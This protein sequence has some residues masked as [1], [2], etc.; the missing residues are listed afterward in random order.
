MTLRS[1]HQFHI[2]VMGL[3]FTIDTALKVARFGISSVLSIVEDQ[4]IERMREIHSN[5]HGL[6]YQQIKD[7]DDDSRARRITAYLDLLDDLIQEQVTALRKEA[8]EKGTE[9]Y[10]YFE[11]LPETSLL[12]KEFNAMLEMSLQDKYIAQEALRSKIVAGSIDVNIMTKLDKTNYD[13]QKNPLPVEYNDAQAALR[14]FANSKCSSSIILSAGMNP[15]LFSYFEA[16]EDFIPNSLGELKKKVI[17]KVSDF[18]SAHIQ[19]KI[20]AKK[21]IWVSEF[22]I[23]SGLNCGGHAFA[24]DG[25]LMGPILEEFSSKR[26]DLLIELG[27]LYKAA[28]VEKK[29]LH[30]ES[31]PEQKLTVQ[32]GVGTHAEHEFLMNYF[33]VDATGWGSPFLLVPEVTNLDKG[34]LSQLASAKKEDYYLSESSPL[35]VP[36]NN[37]RN[38]SSD[39][40]R[41]QRLEKGKPGSPCYKKFLSLNTE[42]T[43]RPVCTASRQY[44]NLKVTEAI[45]SGLSGE[46]LK[47]KTAEI[48]VKDCLCEGLGAPAILVNNETPAHGLNAVSICPGPNL[49]YFSGIFSMKEMVNHIYGRFNALNDVYR[50]NL[51]V[52]ELV[53]YVDYLKKEIN[54]QVDSMTTKQEKFFNNFKTNLVN[55]IEYYR[56]IASNIYPSAIE[57]Q[58][59]M[60]I[61]LEELESKIHS[62][63]DEH[64]V[65]A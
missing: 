63:I 44:I 60:K 10:T 64:I 21:G 38:T 29:S 62:I 52:N 4:L 53:L 27:E 8:F 18:R 49:A 24:T 28:L 5:K 2:P 42:L 36:F 51:F 47:Q 54:K 25:L 22:R 41:L 61:E 45:E 11:L 12:K 59:K 26:N 55:G 58:D 35:G 13:A 39:Q 20:L 40:L 3:G 65:P 32:G 16:F 30:L 7:T 19:G 6:A 14:G 15:R 37:F 48:A 57:L 1:P 17:L 23:E 43:E 33:H 34:T 31:L 56:G 50:P 46:E 9:L